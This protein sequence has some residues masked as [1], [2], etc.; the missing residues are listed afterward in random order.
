MEWKGRLS[1]G[2]E[3][4]MDNLLQGIEGA[5]VSI[6]RVHTDHLLQWWRVSWAS[7]LKSCT[8][9]LKQKW[10]YKWR[11]STHFWS[12]SSQYT[13]NVKAPAFETSM[14]WRLFLGL[15]NYHSKFLPDLLSPLCALLQKHRRWMVLGY[16]GRKSL[17]ESQGVVLLS[18]WVLV[19][20]DS[21]LPLVVILLHV[22]WESFVSQVACPSVKKSSL[23][24]YPVRCQLPKEV[25]QAAWTKEAL[26]LYL[27]SCLSI[28][29]VL[30]AEDRP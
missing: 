12:I 4:M 23:D 26:A 15:V 6:Y 17:S 19:H 3:R 16:S 2:G 30:W 18:S 22:H 7:G 11:W 21:K 28:W 24:S 8:D 14:M 1:V 10:S 20:F 29:L 9:L 25:L 13:H 5:I 27:V